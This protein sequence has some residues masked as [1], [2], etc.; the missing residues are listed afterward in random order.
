[1][2]VAGFRKRS[3]NSLEANAVSAADSLVASACNVAIGRLL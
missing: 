1:V 3:A 2:Q